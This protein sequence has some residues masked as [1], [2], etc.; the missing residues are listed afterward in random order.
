M[1][2]MVEAGLTREQVEAR[3]PYLSKEA[4]E[5]AG[6]P[7]PPN[8][9][10]VWDTSWLNNPDGG[11]TCT[12]CGIE[13][14][15]RF[16]RA[17]Y[18]LGNGKQLHHYRD[19]LGHVHST[20]LELSCPAFSGVNG[21]ESLE[22]KER[23]RRERGNVAEM[24]EYVRTLAARVAALEAEN[25]RLREEREIIDVEVIRDVVARMVEEQVSA[26]LLGTTAGSVL[27][28]QVVDV[29]V[30]EDAVEVPTPGRREP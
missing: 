28:D 14:L 22:M 9:P 18:K 24:A 10:H 21:D 13:K 12:V 17:D 16:F 2:I 20:F 27:D 23:A 1:G 11:M 8:Q 15:P 26:R 29:E 30:V 19:H 25:V 5:R 3:L 7:V 6:K 4:R